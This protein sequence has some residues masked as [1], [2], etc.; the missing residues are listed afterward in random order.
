MRA[1]LSFIPLALAALSCAPAGSTP[2]SS[3]GTI[4]PSKLTGTWQIMTVK[5]L[6]SGEVDSIFKRR[7]LWTQYTRSHWT[8]IYADSGRR[9]PTAAEF[10]KLSPETRRRANYG[11]MFNESGQPG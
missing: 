9:E 10:A 11:K 3:A 7:T 1:G 6:K 8:Y 2:T 4:D 5:N